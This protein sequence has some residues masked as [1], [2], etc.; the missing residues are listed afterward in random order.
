MPHYTIIIVSVS[1]TG[2]KSLTMILGLDVDKCSILEMACIITDK[3]LN[4]IAEVRGND[5]LLIITIFKLY[6]SP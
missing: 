1:C 2:I 3:D 6:K 5:W 4:I